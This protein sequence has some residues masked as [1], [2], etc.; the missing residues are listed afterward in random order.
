M[1]NAHDITVSFSG[2]E[3]F[4]GI[5]FKLNAGDR[6]G[7][8]GKNGAG[9]STLLKIVSGEQEYDRG[10]MAFDKDISL[11]FLKQDIDFEEGRTVIE[12]A[13]QAFKEIKGIEEKL[14]VVNTQLAER[15]DYESDYYHDLMHDLDELSHRY[16]L[17]GGYNYQGETEKILAG[18][19][20]KQENLHQMTNTFSG[21][22]RMRIELAKLLLQK[23]DILLLDEPTNH[24]DIESIIWFEN[25][26]KGFSGAIMMVSHDKMFLD[27][28]TNRT[29][30]I[31]LGPDL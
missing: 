3:L 7:L 16:E 4:S 13:Y 17:I 8:V 31:S 9:K 14:E 22:W 5:T 30:E 26:L 29:I 11:G 2:E 19:G 20:F 24:L 21:G 6:I 27:N 15:T 12:E 23:H 1:L 18:L 10:S 28:V 25:F